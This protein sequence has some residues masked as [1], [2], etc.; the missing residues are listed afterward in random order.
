MVADGLPADSLGEVQVVEVGPL[1]AGEVSLEGVEVLEGVVVAAPGNLRLPEA[2][3]Y[4]LF[5]VA[6]TI[7]I[8]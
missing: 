2:N 4:Y 5:L 3:F 8:L 7:L 1:V 6:K